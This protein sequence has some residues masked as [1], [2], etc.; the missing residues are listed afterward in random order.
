[1]RQLK[2]LVRTNPLQNKS[3]TFQLDLGGGPVHARFEY[4]EAA[5]D[6]ALERV[7]NADHRAFCD[8]PMAAKYLLHP[9]GREPM[10]GDVD[11]VVGATHDIDVA[12]L[13]LEAGVRGLVITRKLREVILLEQIVLLPQRRQTGGWQRQFCDDGS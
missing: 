7:G 2:G 3:D 10:A 12:V 11:D 5:R 4:D 8:F 6:L 1:N 9:T 13:V